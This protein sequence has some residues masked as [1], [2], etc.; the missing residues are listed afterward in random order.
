[1]MRPLALTVVFANLL[2]AADETP[3]GELE[4]YQ[5]TWV[6]VSEEY[7]GK[8]VPAQEL[9]DLSFAVQGNQI[10]YTAQ[11][12]DRSAMVTL[13]PNKTPKAYDLLRD[14]G[15]LSLKGIYTWDGETIKICAAEDQGDRPT[16]FKTGA[17]SRNRIR[18]WKQKK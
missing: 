12:A 15:A 7:E 17:G 5:G 6:L 9:P 8:T 11:G 18:V 10:H 16:E 3:K 2:L 4:K 13:D 14:D 1:M